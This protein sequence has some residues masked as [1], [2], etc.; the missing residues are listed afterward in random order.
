MNY[1]AAYR[2]VGG[3][4]L[5][6][7]VRVSSGVET[8][9]AQVAVSNPGREKTFQVQV[10]FSASTVVVTSGNRSVTASNAGV[11]PGGVG[12]MVD[13]GGWYH[14]IDNFTAAP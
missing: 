11:T 2:E 14:S 7:I 10:T 13:S 4:A 12:L 1:H 6:T 3:S 8:V 9:L 5:L